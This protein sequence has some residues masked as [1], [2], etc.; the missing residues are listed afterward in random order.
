MT[1][2]KGF[3]KPHNAWPKPTDSDEIYVEEIPPT[4]IRVET[5]MQVGRDGN[6]VIPAIQ[7]PAALIGRKVQVIIFEEEEI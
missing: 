6:S 5:T 1:R 7:C 3:I 2:V 4:A